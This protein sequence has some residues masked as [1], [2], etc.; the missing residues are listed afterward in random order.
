[1]A[2]TVALWGTFTLDAINSLF[3]FIIMNMHYC[4]MGTL[5]KVNSK[6]KRARQNS[7]SQEASNLAATIKLNTRGLKVDKTA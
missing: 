7:N 2:G 3:F 1:M 4:G 5:F 6:R